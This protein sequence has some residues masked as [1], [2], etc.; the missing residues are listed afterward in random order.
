VTPASRSKPIVGLLALSLELYEQLAPAIFEDRNRWLRQCVLPALAPVADVRSNGVVCRREDIERTVSEFESSGVEAIVVV[1]AS[2]SP[3]LLT[4]PALLRTSLPLLIW[5][6]QE[7]AT[8]NH[9][10]TSVHMNNNHGVHGTQDLANVLLRAG[11]KFDYITSHLDDPGAVDALAD[12]FTAAASV[13]RMRRLRV[14]LLG[15]PF[16]DMGDLAV[17]TTHL[18]ATLGCRWVRLGLEDYIKRAEAAAPAEVAE[19]VAL[20]HQKYDVS[21][22][23]TELDLEIT[24]RA[25]LSV[26]G[27]VA[28]NRLGAF[29]FQFLALG[30][31][32]RTVTLPFV[33]ASRL[34]ADGVGF[35]GE[36]DLVGAANTWL[37]NQLCEPA[38]FSEIF[39]I[40]FGGNSLFMSHMGE[41]NVAMAPAN[42]KVRLVARPEPIT[43]TRGRQLALATTL[44]PGPAT[45]AALTLGPASRWRIVASRVRVLDFGNLPDMVVPHFKIAPERGDIRDWLT[46]YA[47][48]G[49]PHHSAICF[50]DAMARLRTAAHLM[51]ADFL[52]VG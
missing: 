25:E 3:S 1:C 6:T 52:E 20:Y 31:D 32:C 49:G 37:L 28:E 16:P 46:Q 36:G 4:L 30:E 48:H 2:Y 18:A 45:L 14:G 33:G 13:V 34:M 43:R 44:R 7:L 27:L 9:A 11:R 15:Y 51:D 17:D 42:Q 5:N 10:F 26:R 39:T 8:V 29:T 24:A 22:D 12:W 19:L 35:A 47:L 38:T 41:A 40:D 50:G 21:G 23:V